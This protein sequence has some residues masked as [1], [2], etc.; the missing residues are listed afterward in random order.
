MQSAAQ[1]GGGRGLVMSC[2]CHS[3]VRVLF[4]VALVTSLLWY[5]F[6][7]VMEPVESDIRGLINWC[8]A[9]SVSGWGCTSVSNHGLTSA[10]TSL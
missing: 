8:V 7:V 2:G 4:A 6:W 1:E 3:R 5:L 9:V 10:G